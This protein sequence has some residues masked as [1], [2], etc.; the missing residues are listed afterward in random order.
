MAVSERTRFVRWALFVGLLAFAAQ[1]AFS[2]AFLTSQAIM[3]VQ[4]P[5]LGELFRKYFLVSAGL[6]QLRIL[7]AYSAVGLALSAV[8]VLPFSVFRPG[9]RWPLPVRWLGFSLVL[10]CLH[11][12]F[13]C[14]D[15][16]SHPQNYAE[17][18]YDRGGGWRSLQVLLTDGGV[19]IWARRCSWVLTGACVLP[20]AAAALFRWPRRTLVLGGVV[21]VLAWSVQLSPVIS[22]NTGP[23]V[24]V[25]AVDSFRSDR[26]FSPITPRI[27]RL[28]ETG[29]TFLRAYPDVARTF[30][31]MVTIHTGRYALRHGIR[32]MFPTIEQRA[33]IGQTLP[34]FLRDRGYETAVVADYAGDIFPRVDLGFSRVDCPDFT[35]GTLMEQRALETHPFLLPYVSNRWGMRI[36]PALREFTSLSE[37]AELAAR[38]KEMIGTL[39]RAP[40]FFLT[41]FFSSAHF[42]YAAPHPYYGRFTDPSYRGP[43]KYHKANRIDLAEE[44]LTPEDRAQVRGLYHGALYAADEAAGDL[45]RMIQESP[46][47]SNTSI[48]VTADHGENLYE[49]AR[50]C[51]RPVAPSREG[52]VASVEC[53]HGWMG[54]GDELWNE[55]GLRVPMVF[56]GPGLNP[57][58]VEDVPISLASLAPTLVEWLGFRLEDYGLTDGE[59]LS[60][61]LRGGPPP[62]TPIYLETGAWFVP[63]GPARFHRERI[64]YASLLDFTELDVDHNFEVV[65]RPE[66]EPIINGSKHRAVMEG[67]RRLVYIPLRDRPRYELLRIRGYETA[68]MEDEKELARLKREL[69][70]MITEI[71]TET[72]SSG[73]FVGPH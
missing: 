56:I 4:D 31:S 49:P 58:R 21:L 37:P 28:A 41:I 11:F 15:I 9:S 20:A 26:L 62:E 47:R 68:P 40:R 44:T 14:A 66:Y 70:R 30:P 5:R 12:G 64:P 61:A 18:L 16:Q 52:E 3:G 60:A 8:A 59:S 46:L 50:F 45:I 25:I 6:M 19:G 42:P 73:Y 7:A 71:G 10:M 67:D 39:S 55:E 53:E 24:I 38:G 13:V 35:A 17:F 29:V 72:L 57:R 1:F 65:A 69:E 48:V 34:R 63:R 32:H 2:L 36:F 54:H 51:T 33:A 22:G 27:S 23:N 43:Y